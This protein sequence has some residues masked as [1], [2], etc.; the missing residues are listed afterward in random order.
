MTDMLPEGKRAQFCTWLAWPWFRFYLHSVFC[1][2]RA[3]S[4][5][6]IFCCLRNTSH[7]TV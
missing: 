3:F 6:M 4:T 1:A 5:T 7:V 2:W